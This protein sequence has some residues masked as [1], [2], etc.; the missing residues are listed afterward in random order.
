MWLRSDSILKTA[1]DEDEAL[2][3]W[4]GVAFA[5]IE[6]RPDFARSA[7]LRHPPPACAKVNRP[8]LQILK[9]LKWRCGGRSFSLCHQ[10]LV[11]DSVQEY[12]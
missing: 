6:D 5:L 7:R 1:G 8:E 10:N 2:K 4:L 12:L 9:G 11:L 3:L